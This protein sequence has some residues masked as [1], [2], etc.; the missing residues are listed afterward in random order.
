MEEKKIKLSREQIKQ[1]S[2][3]NAE[4]LQKEI[5]ELKMLGVKEDLNYKDFWRKSEGIHSIFKKITPLEKSERRRLWI[6]F[7]EVREKV[8]EKQAK[9]K[10]VEKRVFEKTSKEIISLLEEVKEIIAKE[11][12]EPYEVETLLF[13]LEQIKLVSKGDISALPDTPE[14]SFIIFRLKKKLVYEENLEKEIA[15]TIKEADKWLKNVAKIKFEEIK[16]SLNKLEVEIDLLPLS[17]LKKALKT[18]SNEIMGPYLVKQQ[19]EELKNQIVRLSE[20]MEKGKK[21][22][23]SEKI[24]KEKQEAKAKEEEPAQQKIGSKKMKE[25]KILLEELEQSILKQS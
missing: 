17:K 6:L 1:L 16:A 13:S 23:S 25:V 11:A 22:N 18:I 20:K 12:A 15:K 21:D 5:V 3:A 9:E 7:Q 2:D 14:K 19:K 4:S 8:K 24:P 10:E